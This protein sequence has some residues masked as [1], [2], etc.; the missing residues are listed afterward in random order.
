MRL[1]F[2]RLEPD[3][4]VREATYSGDAGMPPRHIPPSQ[5]ERFQVIEGP[6]G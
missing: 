2:V 3:E 1:R 5:S 4:L 6:C